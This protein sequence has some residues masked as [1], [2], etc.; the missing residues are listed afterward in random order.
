MLF[1]NIIGLATVAAIIALGY[2]EYKN[3]NR[4]DRYI[5]SHHCCPR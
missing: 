1:I 3:S 2:I 5:A 4:A